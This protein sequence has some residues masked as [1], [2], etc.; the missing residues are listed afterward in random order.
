MAKLLIVSDEDPGTAVTIT[1]VKPGTP[2]KAQGYHGTCT[3]CGPDWVMH[4]W[5]QEK[6]LED[7][8]RHIDKHQGS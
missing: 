8:H 5:S 6:A 2:G 3:E 1:E 4:R 7:A